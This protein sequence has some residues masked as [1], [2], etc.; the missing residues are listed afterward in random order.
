[1]VLSSI[2]NE[3]NSTSLKPDSYWDGHSM[4]DLDKIFISPESNLKKALEIIDQ[5]SIRI[6]LVVSKEGKL[7]GTL[8]DGDV[9]RAILKKGK[10]FESSIEGLYNPNPVICHKR[11]SKEDILRIAAK[12]KVFQIPLVDDERRVIDIVQVDELLNLNSKP[13]KVVLM[14]GGKGTRLSPL[15]NNTPKPML[16]VGDRPILETIIKNFTKFGYENFVLCVNYKSKII[17]EYFGDGSYFGANIEYV[18]EEKSLGTAGALS[19][20]RDK[21]NE[22]FF[23]MNGDLLTNINFDFLHQYHLGQS[24]DATMAVREYDFQVPYGVVSVENSK[25]ISLEEKPVH[26]FFVNAGIY[27]LSPKVLDF[28]EG[29]DYLDMTTLFDRLISAGLS[30]CSFPLREY[31]LDIGRLSD[32][33]KANLEYKKFFS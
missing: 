24:S 10:D 20:L 8:S 33:E 26:K 18:N 15:T 13:N 22:P 6:A 19:Y 16:Q 21:I 27:M 31:W 7:L 29:Q 9:R 5:G 25:I 12:S 11:D 1:M 23:V 30:T 17:Q 4:K 28:I 14:V 3:L 32:Y 2:E